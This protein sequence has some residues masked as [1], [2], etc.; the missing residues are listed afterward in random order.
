MVME[1]KGTAVIAIRDFVKINY[2][3]KYNE[4]VQS[5]P[6]NVK[7][8]FSGV[9]DSSNWYP[10]SEGGLIPTKRTAEMFFNGDYEKGAWDAG[11]YSAQKAL[12]GI[13]K[14]FVKASS[15]GYII[16]RASRVF[17]TYYRPCE[18]NVVDRTEK[19]VKLEI[20]NMTESDV[21]I[22]YRIAGWIQKALEIS[23]ASN[24]SVDITQSISLGDDVTRLEI[25]W[26]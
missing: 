6:D 26:E 1:I 25:C 7:K 8:I 11:R 19:S 24:I 12:T 15:P 18:M 5:L 4:W 21:V 16:Q 10:L 9:I 23:G 22:E 17:A 14:I 20:S 2:G 13:Y 3:D